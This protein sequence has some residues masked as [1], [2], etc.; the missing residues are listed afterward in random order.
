M[1]ISRGLLLR[2][3]GNRC[4]T[5]AFGRAFLEDLCFH[6]QQVAEKALKVVLI[7]HNISF[8]YTH[9]LDE[10]TTG[11]QQAGMDIPS[12]VAG[13]TVLTA[14]AWGPVTQGRS[15]VTG[16]LYRGREYGTKRC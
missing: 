3:S 11:L 10:L 13:A 2:R 15:C 14:F 7:H 5:V 9:D 12:A 4:R 16:R 8:R 6:A 1:I